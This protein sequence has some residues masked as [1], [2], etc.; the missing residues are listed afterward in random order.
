MILIHLFYESMFDGEKDVIKMFPAVHQK[1][2]YL[3]VFFLCLLFL[4]FGVEM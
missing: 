3:N 2:D 4:P 1:H